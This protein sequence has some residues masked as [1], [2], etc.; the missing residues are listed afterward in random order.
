MIKYMLPDKTVVDY[1][2]FIN[3]CTSIILHYINICHDKECGAEILLSCS[4][5]S[6]DTYITIRM[7]EIRRTNHYYFD[8]IIT[9]HYRLVNIY[10]TNADKY[11][12]TEGDIRFNL[13]QAILLVRKDGA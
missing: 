13:K 8:N 6:T 12:P 5:T 3:D 4:M 10:K 9:D 7:A 1:D 2:T 11:I